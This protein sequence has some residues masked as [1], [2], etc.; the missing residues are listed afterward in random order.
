MRFLESYDI[1]LGTCLRYFGTVA[2]IVLILVYIEFQS[3]NMLTG[4][5]ISLSDSYETV[6]HT[7]R[8]TLTGMAQNIVK[9]TLN[10]KEI[11]TDEQGEFVHTLVLERGYTIMSLYAEDRFGR[12]TVLTKE[13]VYVPLQS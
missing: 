12:S 6:Q 11:T 7:G 8:I 5:T 13:F 3:R 9:L 10:G 1:T 2:L 4:P